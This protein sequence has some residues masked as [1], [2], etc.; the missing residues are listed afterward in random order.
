MTSSVLKST[1]RDT[2]VAPEREAPKKTV[3][4]CAVVVTYNRK[5]LLK[6]CL[7]GIMNQSYPVSHILVV[8]NA[9]TD[10]TV[11][12][13]R[14][15]PG[16]ELLVLPENTGGAGGFHAGFKR[17]AGID[18]NLI[19]VMDD[20]ALPSEGACKALADFYDG[21]NALV[22]PS[23]PYEKKGALAATE[24]VEEEFG[25]FV[26]MALPRTLV[27]KIG[28][29]HAHYFIYHDDLEYSFRIHK[30]GAKI[31]RLPYG[32][33][34]HADMKKVPREDVN[35]LGRKVSVPEQPSWKLY[36]DYRNLV[37]RR[38]EHE[39]YVG[40]K[41]K[42]VKVIAL[43]ALLKIFGKE[44]HQEKAAMISKA[45]I[46]ALLGRSGRRVTP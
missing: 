27:E 38:A 2:G 32:P 11:E 21:K 23:L 17:A 19:W 14:E 42:A 36:Y 45:G 24:P 40:A 10:G 41:F 16:L 18:C 30:A 1:G 31:L 34:Y 33:I 4:I 37:F 28:Y 44:K 15:Y 26:G 9:S 3:K 12:M 46:D 20:D 5:E 6:R 35:I 13:L 8:D 43:G 39:G 25:I 7:D 22:N 29:P